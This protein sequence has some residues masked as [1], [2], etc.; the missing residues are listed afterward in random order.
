[1][2]AKKKK[3]L[4]KHIENLFEKKQQG[5]DTKADLNKAY[6][7]L[8]RLECMEAMGIQSEEDVPVTA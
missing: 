8:T 7:E 2:I 5:C 1:M 3:N 6:D 4:R